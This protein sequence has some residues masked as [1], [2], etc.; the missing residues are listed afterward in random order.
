MS[1]AASYDP[2]ADA[3]YLRRRAGVSVADTV[4]VQPRVIVDL[5]ADGA[6][7]GVELLAAARHGIPTGELARALGAGV[8]EQE[9]AEAAAQAIRGRSVPPPI[10]DVP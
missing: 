8:G 2:S 10:A 5:G 7:V 6:S 9:V 1:L 4:E 3:L